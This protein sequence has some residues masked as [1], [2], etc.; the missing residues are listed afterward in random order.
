MEIKVLE[1]VS[2]VQSRI[3]AIEEKI[4]GFSTIFQNELNQAQAAE[5]VSGTEEAA[6]TSTILTDQT[7]YS[8]LLNLLNSDS[9]VNS[10]LVNTD[11]TTDTKLNTLQQLSGSSTTDVSSILSTYLQN[12]NGT[13]TL[14]GS[15][16]YNLLGNLSF[17]DVLEKYASQ[18]I[19]DKQDASTKE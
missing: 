14:L 5:K 6:S 4:S 10:L 15:S 18:M 3:Q 2:N 16:G 12:M 17:T 9:N 1:S 8:T 13:N 7:D 11:Q 19:G